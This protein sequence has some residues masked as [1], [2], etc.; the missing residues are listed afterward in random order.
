MRNQHRRWEA[1]NVVS[2]QLRDRTG[3]GG[4]FAANCSHPSAKESAAPNFSELRGTAVQR[5]ALSTLQ[6]HAAGSSHCAP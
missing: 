4:D 3:K 2:K 5:E 1:N 6:V